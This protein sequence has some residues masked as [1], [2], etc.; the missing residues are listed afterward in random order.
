MN[1]MIERG[2]APNTIIR[3]DYPYEDEDG[4]A[5]IHFSD[6]RSLRSDGS[7]S[8]AGQ[9][10]HILTNKELKWLQANGYLMGR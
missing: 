9:G 8:H 3:I 2:Q 1:I 5:H 7:V 6:G 4:L 10:E